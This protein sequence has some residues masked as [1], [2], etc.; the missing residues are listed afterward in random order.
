VR[1]VSHEVL[2]WRGPT[3]GGT[4]RH[5][6]RLRTATEIVALLEAARFTVEAAYGGWFMEHLD[7]ESEH[8]ILVAR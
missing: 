1:G 3:G 2:R 6:L 7:Q 8:L 5:S 4:K